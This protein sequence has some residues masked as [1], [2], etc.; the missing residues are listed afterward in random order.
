MGRG[1][2]GLTPR[3]RECLATM[4]LRRGRSAVRLKILDQALQLRTHRRV[5][6]AG[7]RAGAASAGSRCW[8]RRWLRRLC[9]GGTGRSGCRRP[10]SGP[11]AAGRPLRPRAA[12]P[13]SARRA[14]LWRSRPGREVIRQADA[15]P[16]HRPPPIWPGRRAPPR[17]GRACASLRC[18]PAAAR[19]GRASPSTMPRTISWRCSGDMVLG[20]RHLIGGGSARRGRA[21]LGFDAELRGRRL[22]LLLHERRPGKGLRAPRQRV[23]APAPGRRAAPRPAPG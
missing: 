19:A 18:R 20:C 21:A 5:W 4:A 14:T 22:Q 11:A 17:N 2:G 9:R 16:G 10:A 6:L 15:P 1:T 12:G 3:A 13:G 7:A 23:A 8:R